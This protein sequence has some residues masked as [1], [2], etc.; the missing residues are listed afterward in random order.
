M[1]QITLPRNAIVYETNWEN[2][3][4]PLPV[5]VHATS[6]KIQVLKSVLFRFPSEL[7]SLIA[8]YARSFERITHLLASPCWKPISSMVKQNDSHF[9]EHPMLPTIYVLVVA[10]FLPAQEEEDFQECIAHLVLPT[11]THACFSH[12]HHLPSQKQ[13]SRAVETKFFCTD[14]P[15]EWKYAGNRTLE[16]YTDQSKRCLYDLV[17]VPK[18]EAKSSQSN[19]RP[20]SAP[21]SSTAIRLHFSR[22]ER[23]CLQII[24]SDNPTSTTVEATAKEV[25]DNPEKFQQLLVKL[26]LDFGVNLESETGEAACPAPPK[27]NCVIA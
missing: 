3:E 5:V 21:S 24:R 11:K 7:L 9:F 1:S 18:I 19:G 10:P 20:R 15:H 23:L 17:F 22:A 27:S 6:V 8:A 14:D 26:F 2:S 16:V 25:H 13:Q 12:T 4:T